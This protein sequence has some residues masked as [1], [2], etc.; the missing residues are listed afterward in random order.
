MKIVITGA[1]GFLGSN[2]VKHFNEKQ[3]EIYAI[4]RENSNTKQLDKNNI[5]YCVYNGNVTELIEFFN[6]RKPDVVIH[7]AAFFV[8]EHM[9][10]QVDNLIDSNIRFST[11]ILEA[12][13]RTGVTNFINTSTVWEH[14]NNEEYNPSCLYAATKKVVEDIIKYYVE[15]EGLKAITLVLYDTYGKNDRRGKIISKFAEIIHTQEEIAMS[16]GE[17]EIG[18]L[19]IDDV[20]QAYSIA[21]NM[22]QN[23]KEKYEKYYLLPNEIHSLKEIAHIFEEVSGKKLLTRWG[24][25]PYRKREVMKVYRQGVCLPGWNPSI[26]LYNGIKDL[27]EE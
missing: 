1:T 14:Y 13:S 7:T 18:L 16:K 21:V 6:K 15:A 3:Y 8:S 12:M 11:H 19:H 27:M 20:V 25:R 2:L 4:V 22:F 10:S 26:D 24:E 23:M 17:Q 9:Y 5:E